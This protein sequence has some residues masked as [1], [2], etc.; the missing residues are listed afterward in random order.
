MTDTDDR[1][2]IPEYSVSE[3]SSSIRQTVENA[4]SYVRVRGEIS[5]YKKAPSGHVYLTLK[6]DNA[7]LSA[8]CWKGVAQSFSFA[9]E[10]GLE[11]I[12]TGRITT[13]AGQSKYQLMVE[14]MEPAGVG[15]L[16]ALLEKRK[17]QFEKEGLF[18]Q[19]HKKPL[20]FLPDVIGVITSPT[21][22]VIKDILHRIEER[23]PRKILLWPVLVQGDK[24]AKQIADAIDGFNKFDE[25]S[26]YPPPDVIIVARGGGSIE[27]LWPF[28]EEIVVRA[29]FNS[30][31]PLI[32]AVG[33]ETDTT[34]IDYVSDVRAPTPTAAAEFAVPRRDE[35]IAAMVDYG[36]RL[37][38]TIRRIL[39][40]KRSL[41][42]AISRGLPN[43]RRIIEEK[44]QYFDSLCMRFSSSLAKLIDV[45]Q[46]KLDA[47]SSSIKKPDHLL[48]INSVRLNSIYERV[49]RLTQ[50]TI[51]NNENKLNMAAKLL[52]TCDYKRV[53]K[54]GF[55]IVRHKDGKLIASNSGVRKNQAMQIEFHDGKSDVVAIEGHAKKKTVKGSQDDLFG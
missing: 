44:T 51:D 8:I 7:N 24:A 18:D 23:F 36:Q 34:L 33:H 48:E 40:E 6:D 2:N 32:S 39:D 25:N 27:D 52:K 12:C 20:P 49:V 54:R 9:P 41:V 30:A 13:Y 4:F 14:L 16:M 45:K 43:Q 47:V 22:A 10:D 31:I 21:G 26:K 15:A 37:N 35:L 46:H 42:A 17:K 55:A 11:V 19:K 29:A 50:K 5:G 28:N 3:I 1:Q 38:Q 53:L